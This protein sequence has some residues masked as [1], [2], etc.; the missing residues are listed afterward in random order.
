[1]LMTACALA[2][3]LSVDRI[4]AAPAAGEPAPR[5]LNVYIDA[6]PIWPMFV[7][8]EL[9]YSGFDLY[10]PTGFTVTRTTVTAISSLR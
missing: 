8:G 10:L 6:A 4:E 5:V 1:M 9:N 2:V 3:V 7:L